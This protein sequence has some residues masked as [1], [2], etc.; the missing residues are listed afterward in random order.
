[1]SSSTLTA[2]RLRQAQ[3]GSGPRSMPVTWERLNKYLLDAGC[4][5]GRVEIILTLQ[6]GHLTSSPGFTHDTNWP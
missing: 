2:E 3:R 4:E 1:M 5:E 6:P